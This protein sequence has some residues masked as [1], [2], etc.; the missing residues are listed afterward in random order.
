MKALFAAIRNR[1]T[2][3]IKELI[4]KK[5]ELVNSI[6]KQPPKKDDGQ[7]P[8]QVAFKS[9]NF[10]AVRYFIE[11]GANVNFIDIQSVNE[12]KMPVL[13]N[14]IMATVH[15]ARFEVPVNPWD[16]NQKDIYEIK[17]VK[18]H[19]DKVFLLLQT[20]VNQGAD[21]NAVDSYGNTALMR[22]CADANNRW[23]NKNRP[24]AKETIEDL[25]QIFDLLIAKGADIYHATST[26]KP[27]T[28]MS[29]TLL[30]QIGI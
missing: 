5:P 20:M 19:F 1:D 13:H 23:V 12:W 22:L 25:K 30:K 9:K 10:W 14:A 29:K 6:A 15:M 18:E 4:G 21:T 2:E 16:E 11:K 17:G 7:S 28:E 3:K 24:L 8:L 26:R 27:I